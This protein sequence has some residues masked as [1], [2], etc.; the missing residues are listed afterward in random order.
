MHLRKISKIKQ[1]PAKLNSHGKCSF[2]PYTMCPLELMQHTVD[3]LIVQKLKI[4]ITTSGISMSKICCRASHRKVTRRYGPY[5]FV[6]KR[7]F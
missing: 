2:S 6:P 3:R 1:K 7:C 5:E 4:G